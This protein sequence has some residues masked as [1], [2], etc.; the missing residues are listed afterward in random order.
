MIV[1]AYAYRMDVEIRHLEA[2]R[3]VV[4]EGTFRGAAAVL[5]YSQ[6]AISQQIAALEQAVGHSVLDRPGGPRAAVLTPTGRILLRH[7][8][9]ILEEL[10][11]ARAEVADLHSGT[12]GRLV[13]GTFQSASVQLLPSIVRIVLQNNPNLRVRV[14]E[15]A[16]NEFLL[17]RLR[18]GQLD[19]TFVAGPLTVDDVEL[20]D[21]GIDP[22]VVVV[23]DDD[24]TRELTHYPVTDLIG[25]GLIGEHPG[26]TQAS[27]QSALRVHGVNPHYLFR[28]ND[29]G[30]IQAMARTG[31][32]PAIMPLL[33]VDTADPEVRVLPLDPPIPPRTIQL[34]LPRAPLR[35][36]AAET[37]ARVA[38]E[39]GRRRLQRAGHPAGHPHH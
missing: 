4:E 25:V 18:A 3:A 5:G 16:E 22:Y 8:Q 33:A 26:G 30:A 23:A 11:Q 31:L 27:I 39:V 2:L 20:H 13:C 36:A 14:I 21:I 6:A 15:E 35:T 19:L 28:S 17:E 24:Q 32:G 12:S 7:G 1:I 29:N 38:V 10:A 9:A 34:A 37:F